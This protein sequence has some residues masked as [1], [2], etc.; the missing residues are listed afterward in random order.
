MVNKCCEREE[1][2]PEEDYF[3]RLE[4]KQVHGC[5]TGEIMYEKIMKERMANKTR[6]E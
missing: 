5:A 6:E 4:L 2:Q 1:E 3:L